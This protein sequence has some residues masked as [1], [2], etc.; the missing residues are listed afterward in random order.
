MPRGA[1]SFSNCLP[2]AV[3]KLEAVVTC[4]PTSFTQIHQNKVN[5][6]KPKQIKTFKLWIWVICLEVTCGNL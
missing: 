2:F 5:E 1:V 6:S 3:E 4:P